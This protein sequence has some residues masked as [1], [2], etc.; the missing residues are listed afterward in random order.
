MLNY[1]MKG[2][3]HEIM[4]ASQTIENLNPQNELPLQYVQLQ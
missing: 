3:T 4:L 2:L 1:A